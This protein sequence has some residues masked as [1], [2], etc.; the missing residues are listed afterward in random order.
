MTEQISAV[1]T[2]APGS[3]ATHRSDWPAAAQALPQIFDDRE[4]A[5]K[6]L[7]DFAKDSGHKLVMPIRSTKSITFRCKAYKVSNCTF[8]HSQCGAVLL[9]IDPRR[10]MGGQRIPRCRTAAEFYGRPRASIRR[11]SLSLWAG[12]LCWP[13]QRTVQLYCLWMA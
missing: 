9:L 7:K 13:G 10:C 4:T 3:T 12:S 6:A 5:I 8:M 2:V 1:P 11:M